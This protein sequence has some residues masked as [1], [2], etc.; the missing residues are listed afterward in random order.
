ML[1]TDAL[2]RLSVKLRRIYL[3]LRGTQEQCTIHFE[4]NNWEEAA[5]ATTASMFKIEE[6]GVS[7]TRG[8]ERQSCSSLATF[9]GTNSIRLAQL[10][11]LVGRLRNWSAPHKA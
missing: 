6:M 5:V 11:V 2:R 3:R 7:N 9:P 4:A 10:P 1:M 8:G